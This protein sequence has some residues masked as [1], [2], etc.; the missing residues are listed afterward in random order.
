MEQFITKMDKKVKQTLWFLKLS[1]ECFKSTLSISG[2]SDLFYPT[3]ISPSLF[4]LNPL[5]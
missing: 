4:I 1:V 3:S 2:A 5:S